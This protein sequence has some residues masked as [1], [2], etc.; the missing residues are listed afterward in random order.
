MGMPGDF[1]DL[2]VE[3]LPPFAR[4]SECISDA[5]PS[6]APLARV[7][8]SDIAPR[9]MIEAGGHW[10]PWRADV[11]PYMSEPMDTTLSRRFDSVAFVGPARSSK[12]E[13]L[14][15]NP[16]VHAILAQPGV[17]SVFSPSKDAAQEWS[18]GALD[19]LVAHSPELSSRL[20]SGKGGD[21]VFGKRFR[22]GTRLTIDWPVKSKLAQRS[23]KLVIGTDYDAFDADIGGDGE[24]FPLMRKR[25]ESAG[26]RGMT[27][28]ESSPRRPILDETWSPS[29]PHEA[30]PCEGIVGIYNSGSRGRL[31]WHCPHCGHLDRKSVV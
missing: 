4:V 17:V 19:P 6:L 9:R 21:N 16:L 5:L 18:M 28:V 8:V 12:S 14:V 30:P 31:Y 13:G 3:P 2:D 11:A 25:T 7:S 29:T 10:V 27:V 24:A 15:I 26:S 22:G 1:A 23:I 20:M